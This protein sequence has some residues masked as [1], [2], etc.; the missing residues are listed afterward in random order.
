MIQ[1]EEQEKMLDRLTTY[2]VVIFCLTLF[3]V[4]RFYALE[5]VVGTSMEPTYHSGD[6]LLATK[7][8]NDS[9]LDYGAV[10]IAV[11]LKAD[12]GGE[13][14]IKRVVGMPGDTLQVK[15]GCLYVNGEKRQED[16]PP[17]KTPGLLKDELTLTDDEYFLM[18]DNRNNSKDSRMFG[19]VKANEIRNVILY[20]I[21]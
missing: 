12:T 10:V 17:I 15:D 14:I 2:I 3:I 16:T 20:R 5:R 9:L 11:P 13:Q 19:P 4:T 1:T 21:F 8:P 6:L 7:R 18:G